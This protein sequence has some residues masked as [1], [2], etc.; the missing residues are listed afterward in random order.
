MDSDLTILELLLLS[1][2]GR[3]NPKR[4]RELAA[5]E[6][7]HSSD[8]RERSEHERLEPTS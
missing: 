2:F 1:D 3:T 6:S 4:A 8:A 7:K 5:A